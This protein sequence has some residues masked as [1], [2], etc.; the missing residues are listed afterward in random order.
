MFF[1]NL[2]GE[3]FEGIHYRNNG[4]SFPLVVMDTDQEAK[5]QL[6]GNELKVSSDDIGDEIFKLKSLDDVA[7]S[8][9]MASM[10]K[11]T[12]EEVCDSD[13]NPLIVVATD[14]IRFYN[15]VNTLV[16]FVFVNSEVMLAMLVYGACEFR[17]SDGRYVPLQ[18]CNTDDL[19]RKGVYGSYGIAELRNNVWCKTKGGWDKTYEMVCP[20][21]VTTWRN[22]GSVSVVFN[23]MKDSAFVFNGEAIKKREEYE[24]F[25]EEEER[26]RKE[27]ADKEAKERRKAAEE[28]AAQRK[29]EEEEANRKAK[30]AK[31]ASPKRKSSE[32]TDTSKRSSGAE[33]F[34]AM[35]NGI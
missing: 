17:L 16:K 21:C 3:K 23:T 18:R 6:V 32:S 10:E 27:K 8:A 34:L 2:V 28:R 1:S 13:E 9:R 19:D 4:K 35:I 22:K 26:I 14:G 12:F 31:S 11:F 20:V 5:V 24:A 30:E 29:K 33:A 15:E 7:Y 25:R